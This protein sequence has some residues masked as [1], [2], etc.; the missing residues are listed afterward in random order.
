VREEIL[1]Q[2]RLYANTNGGVAP[3][4]KSFTNATGIGKHVW[5]GKYWARWSDAVKEAGIAPL[6][7]NKAIPKTT[8]FGEL[9]KIFRHFGREPTRAEFDLYRSVNTG[10][11]WYQTLLKIFGTKTQMLY[12]FV[13]WL[14]VENR[15]D[16]VIEMLPKSTA[17][18]LEVGHA[19]LEGYVYLLRS[20]QNFKIGRGEDVEKRIKQIKISLPDRAELIHSIRTDDPSGIEA[21]W[22]RRFEDKRANGE[23]FK[24]TTR[25]VAAFKKRKFQ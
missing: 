6:V 3:G 8:I 7:R 17:S 2:I 13:E 14:E 12:E 11:P 19:P 21:Y 4:I 9:V 25:D 18:I 5:L 16:D 22:H 24:L 1:H 15:F 20:G 10:L 23:W